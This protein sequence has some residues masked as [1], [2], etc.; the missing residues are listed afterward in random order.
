MARINFRILLG[1]AGLTALV[2]VYAELWQV[3]SANPIELT[4]KDFI[5]QYAAGRIADSGNWRNVYDLDTQIAEQEQILGSPILSNDFPPF[6]HPPFILPAFALVAHLDYVPAWRAWAVIQGLFLLLSALTLLAAV[7]QLRGRLYIFAG[8]L[9]FFPAFI[10]LLSGQDSTLLL[11]GISLW[12]YGLLKGKDR[13]AGIGLALASLRP[14]VAL[15]L[16]IPFIFKQRKVLG[17]FLGAIMALGLLSFALVGLQGSIGFLRILGISAQGQGY[18]MNEIAMVN[19]VGL[20]MRWFPGIPSSQA[21]LVG[22]VG[23]GLA[24]GFLCLLWKRSSRI[25]EKQIGLAVLMAIFA[26]PHLHYHDLILL[27]IPLICL[28]SWL[29]GWHSP[30]AGYISLLP[31][32]VSWILLLSN[33]LDLFKYNV[34]Y[35][36]GLALGLAFWLPPAF[37]SARQPAQA[38]TED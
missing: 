14:Q 30:A 15:L 37:L 9:A 10:S 27:L 34:P 33:S 24:A 36:V 21:H 16:A 23:Y 31:L 22:W 11:L 19:L 3:M 7:P 25:A 20:L 35:L 8:I 32:A 29:D 5:S 18:F 1:I 38:R 6:N 12:A 2:V 26:A 28:M 4:R 13:T 17:W